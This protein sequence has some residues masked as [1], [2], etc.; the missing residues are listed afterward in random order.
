MTMDDLAKRLTELTPEKRELLQQLLARNGLQ[1]S[2]LKSSARHED[3]AEVSG[4]RSEDPAGEIQEVMVDEAPVVLPPNPSPAEIKAYHRSVYNRLN[5]QLNSTPYSR[6]IRFCNFGYLAD[7]SPQFSQVRLPQYILNKNTIQLVLEVIG[8]CD[9]TGCEI[10][11]VGC[12][13]GGTIT[14]ITEYFQ[15]KRVAGVDLSSSAIAFCRKN[16]PFEHVAYYE[17]DA[18]ELPFQDAEFDVIVNIE[19]SHSYPAIENFYLGVFRLLRTGGYFLYAD[20]FPAYQWNGNTRLLQETGFFV[21]QDRDI[22]HNVLLSC[23]QT[24]T[25]KLSAYRPDND[26][27]FMRNYLGM[28]DSNVY[29]GM[30]NGT[31]MY[32]ILKLRKG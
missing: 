14:V 18:E 3:V 25:S 9:L 10:L 29:N 20:L 24:A 28:P 27:E 12:G 21:E 5:N 26:P 4:A 31:W 15:P 11:D 32:K 6:H 22:T 17:G 13:R 19:S 30:Q 16:N 1:I 7:S 23:E 2:D 8:D